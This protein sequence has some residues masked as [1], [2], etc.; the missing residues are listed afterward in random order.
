MKKNL[1]L[2]AAALAGLMSMV[3]CS[4]EE[5]VKPQNGKREEVKTSFTL[6]VGSVKPG[7]R[8]STTSVQAEGTVFQGMEGIKL[9]PFIG[10][11][12][13]DT[14]ITISPIN[15]P[16]FTSFDGSTQNAKVYN[17]VSIPIGVDHFVFYGMIANANGQRG[18]GRLAVPYTNTT[19]FRTLED[20]MYFDLVSRTTNMTSADQINNNANAKAVLE[21]LNGVITDLTNLQANDGSNAETYG[22]YLEAWKLMRAGSSASVLALAEALYNSIY[23]VNNAVIDVYCPTLT[24]KFTATQNPNT[25]YHTLKWNSDPQFPGTYNLPDGAVVVNYDGASREFKY[26]QGN[27]DGLNLPTL[28]KFVYP[29]QLAY[30]V[31]TKAMV[32]NKQQ[33]GLNAVYD[34][35]KSNWNWSD[36]QGNDSPFQT[37]K[38]TMST[39]SVVLKD[40]IQFAVGQL[41]TMVRV[42]PDVAIYDNGSNVDGAID[43]DEQLVQVPAKGYKLTGVLIGGQK[44]V[45]WQFLPNEGTTEYTIYDND[46]TTEIA[47]KQQSDFSAANY[48]LALET[49]LDADI[50]LCLEFENTGNPFFGVNHQVIPTN[51]KFYLITDL[52][53]DGT[54]KVFEQ[55]HITI[56]RL[57]IGKASLKSAYNVIPDLRSPKLELGLSVDLKWQPGNSF[58]L[59]F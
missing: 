20:N 10:E 55:D 8:M 9:F 15:L 43:K 51:G 47:A 40:Q 23:N 57:T 30:F 13:D 36:V 12:D 44:Q 31:K 59:E 27:V 45:D 29:A 56:A 1:F 7:T 26:V 28:D 38:V 21:V 18:N 22:K 39:Q 58:N 52:V 46:M 34:V 42:E 54:K 4:S 37:G 17:D 11:P 16:D 25:E 53:V 50:K 5:E 41:Q 6:S 2:S 19:L 49:A 33:F 48:T 3:S 35:T 32:S 14:P 24:G